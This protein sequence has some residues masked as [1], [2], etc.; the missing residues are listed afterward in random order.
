MK[1][2]RAVRSSTRSCSSFNISIS[3]R[4]FS[5]SDIGFAFRCRSAGIAPKSGS[6]IH[7]INPSRPLSDAGKGFNMSQ[8]QNSRI[9]LIAVGPTA[10]VG[11]ARATSAQVRFLIDASDSQPHDPACFF[12]AAQRAQPKPGTAAGSVFVAEPAAAAFP[13]PH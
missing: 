2:T 3:C 8:L 1:A 9:C 6:A 5:A 13:M 12:P 7:L 11:A 10:P 4:S